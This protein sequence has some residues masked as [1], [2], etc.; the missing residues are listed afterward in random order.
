M[1]VLYLNT[2]Y[3]AG[4]VAGQPTALQRIAGSIPTRRNSLRKSQI[5]IMDPHP[6]QR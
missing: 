1:V 6:R 3:T 4:T 2:V 5:V